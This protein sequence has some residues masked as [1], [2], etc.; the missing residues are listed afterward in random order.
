MSEVKLTELEGRVRREPL[1]GWF[2]RFVSFTFRIFAGPAGRIANSMPQLRSQIL[3]SNLRTSPEGLVSMALF[4]TMVAGVTTV[5]LAVYGFFTLHQ[6][7]FLFFP[8]AIPIVYLVITSLPKLSSSG[9]A[10]AIDTELPF[11]LGYMSVLAGGGVSPIETLRRISQMD[12]LP[13]SRKEA[14]RILVDTDVFGFDPITAMENASKQSPS[15]YWSEFLAGYTAVLKSGG[16]FENY[17]QIKL[18]DLVANRSAVVKNASDLTGS[19][20]EA[21]LTITVV[22]GMTLYTL[23]M[24][25]AMLSGNLGALQN[26]YLFAFLVV[27]LISAGFV[28]LIDAIQTKWPYTDYRPYKFFAAM[29]PVAL[30]VLFIPIPIPLYLHVSV[31]LGVASGPPASYSLRIS[32]ERRRLERALPDFIGDVTEGRK[33]G[34]SPEQSIERLSS[35]NY[36]VLSR[37]VK[38]MGAQLSWG[39]SLSKVIS[40][41]TG[42]VG[43][44]VTRATGVLLIEVVDVGGGTVRSFTEMAAFARTINDLETQKR[45]ALKPFVFITYIAGIMVI[46][47]TFIL[48][49]MLSAPA[50]LGYKA[51]TVDS[52]TI[53]LLLTTAVFDS[54]V[55][56]LVAGKMGESSLSDGFKHGFALVIAS[57]VSV[58]IAR[59]FINI[60]L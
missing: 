22:L 52:H 9:R 53:D 25:Q 39:V 23:Y 50:T 11:V 10:A 1:L 55:I 18:R 19:V 46:M 41:F 27:P 15:R 59:L 29:I 56:G 20:A 37:H 43:S 58:A 33:T 34:L 5:F 31:A 17:I 30:V 28:Y 40:T 35:R 24:V 38:K 32:R 47:T 44:W 42:A 2:D 49:Y 13:A 6:V 16:S 57:V 60:P 48:V 3:K 21:Y 12:V 54:F 8:V 45:S 36:G 51:A 7:L 14:K 26:L 4:A